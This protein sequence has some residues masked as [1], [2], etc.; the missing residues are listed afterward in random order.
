M[1]K[2]I[3]VGDKSAV[4]LSLLCTL[5]CIVTPVVL[6]MLSSVSGALAFDPEVLHFWLLFAVIPISLFAMITG[7]YHHRKASISAISLV[8]MLTLIS[9]VIF[10]HDIMA[11][12]GEIVLT[13][14]GSMLVAFGH[15]KS[16]KARKQSF[17]AIPSAP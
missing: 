16:L 6:V 12:K 2:L 5:H 11:G 8:G 4:V 13:L 15:I 3:D 17:T 14:I 7:Y 9:A 1:S 10:G